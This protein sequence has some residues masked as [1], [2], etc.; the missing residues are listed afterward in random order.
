MTTPFTSSTLNSLYN[1][2]FSEDKNFHQILFNDGRAL[3]ARELTQLQTLI[4]EELGRFGRNIFK[5]GAAVSS[6]GTS[7]NSAYEFVRIA[8]T[9]EGQAFADI[10][11]GTILLNPLTNVE[12]RVL[13]VHPISADF[14]QNTLYVQ[15][16]STGAADVTSVATR[17]GDAETLYDQS[18][19]NYELV[20]DTPN[21]TG[22]GVRFDVFDG[23]FF[24]AGRFVHADA[25]SIVLSP[26]TDTANAVVGFKVVQEIVT[27]NDDISLYD[28]AGG[29]INTASPGGDRYKIT[30]QLTTQDKVTSDDTFVFIARVENSKI[31]EE[32][33]ESDAFNKINDLLALRTNEESG[34][35][36]VNPFS[37][38][39]DNVTD[40]SLDLIISSGT[41]YVNGYR[42]DNPSP[43]R[44]Q[45]PKPKSTE[46]I[47]N[48]VVPVVYGNYFEV[49]SVRG[50]PDLD[51]S[52][53]NLRTA[54]A[55]GGSTIGSAR[56]R[57]VEK[58]Q[59]TYRAY[60]F[61]VLVDSDQ[62]IST[63]Q[64]IG[65][66]ATSYLN[67]LGTLQQTT[68]N[69]LLFPTSRPRPETF[70]DI[71]MVVQDRESKLTD[72]SG[73]LNL[74]QLPVGETYTDTSLWLVA[75]TGETFQAPTIT[76][77]NGNRDA[78]LSG[79]S[80]STTYEIMFYK[81]ITATRKSKTLTTTSTT[82][83]RQTATDVNGNA[84]FYYDLGV[85]DIYQLDSARITDA[86]GADLLGQVSLD[87]G[88]RDNYYADGRII[89]GI[90]DS[91]PA[92][93]YASFQHFT[94]GAGDFYDATSYD[95][96]YADIPTHSKQDGTEVKLFNYLDF[97]PDKNDG[98]FSNINLLPRNGS[99]ITADI[100][101]YLPRADKLLVTQEGDFQVLMGQQSE[102]PQYKKTPE[103][104]LELYKILLN[105]N[106]LDI[107]DM[108]VTP[109]EHK[110]YTMQDIAKIEAKLD[111]L[112]E[113][114][115][116]KFLELEQ[117]P[118]L[119][120]AGVER[121]VS[122]LLADD[123]SDQSASDVTNRDYRASLD[124]E[125]KVIKPMADE[126]NIRLIYDASSTGVTKVGDQ[127][128]LNYDSEQWQFQDL[129]SRFVNINPFGAVDNVGTLKLSPSS[130]E[131]KDS[132]EEAESAIRGSNKLAKS[133][134]MLWNNWSWN[135]GG[136]SSEDIS[137][138][139]EYFTEEDAK[140]KR[141]KV[142]SENEK[143]FSSKSSIGRRAGGTKFVSRVVSDETLRKIANGRVVD[144]AIV[145]WMRSRKIYFHAK[146]L[147]PNSKFT[148]FF[149]G[150]N[151]AVWC[152]QEEAFINWADRDSDQGNLLTQNTLTGRLDGSSELI[153]DDNGE[154]IGS[155][156]IP[157]LRPKYYADNTYK[158]R[159]VKQV[160][161]RFR[162]GTREFK[163]LDIDNNDWAAAGSK[164]FAYYTAEGNIDRTHRNTLFT[165]KPSP[166]SP[167]ANN[168]R[169]PRIYTPVE[170]R[171]VL[172]N[173]RSDQI[174][175]TDPRSSGLYSPETTAIN[176]SGLVT[177]D[178][179][180]QMSSILSDYIDVDKNQYSST[181]T[182]LNNPTNPMTQTFT[183]DNQYGLV[184]T[185][186]DLFFRQKDSGNLPVA[187][188][189]RPVEGGKP[190]STTIVPDSHVWLNPSQVTAI[191]LDPQLS[192]IRANP[193][194]FTFDEPVFLQPWTTY[195]IVVT[196]QSTEYELFSA[197]TKE[198]V[199]GST[200]R[201]VTTQPAPGALYLPQSGRNWVES[202]DQDLMFRL[203]RAK[204]SLGGG[205]LILK[206]APLPEELL[207][208]NPIRTVSGSTEIYIRNRCHGLEVG[209]DV[210][211]QGAVD[212]GSATGTT[213]N[214]GGSSR[215]VTA[216]DL[217]GFKVDIGVDPAVS[218]SGGGEGVTVTKNVVFSTANTVLESTI[219]NKTSIDVGAKL[220]SGKYI[221]G[222]TT[223]F[224]RNETFR[225]VTPNQNVDFD[226]PY[227][228]YNATAETANL[229]AG[230]SSAYIKVDLKTASDYVSPLIDLQRASL[231]LA[232]YC[233][234]N[235]TL[236]PHI[237]P[238]DETSPYGG[239]TGAKHITTPVTLE[240][241]AVGIDTNFKVNLPDGA[242][243]KMYYRTAS[244]DE[245]IYDKRWILQ[246]PQS[247]IP[248]VNDL[249]L[250][251]AQFLAGG[252]GGY[253]KPFNQS[254]IK[255]VGT[256]T[257]QPFLLKD[258]SIRFL[259]I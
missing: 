60:V 222:N 128:T 64:S 187:I 197:K 33:E 129:A 4:Y 113:Y 87:D 221:S 248:N 63:V 31:V 56:I 245:N 246:E 238:V 137:L 254:Q 53:V 145:P 32:I 212:I 38:H 207:D 149:D 110:S 180:G 81:Q 216:I 204:F 51:Y 70:D 147:K 237:Y 82:F 139:P 210:V 199:Y 195:A 72:G 15:Y 234:D 14:E 76:L 205:S 111:K 20:T 46:S 211:I 223:R 17:F 23:D 213:I 73:V 227:A 89:M 44:L 184:L 101:Y 142:I 236:T 178:Q 186:L 154:I 251:N 48:D 108:Q 7:I 257:N 226:T 9:N 231:V 161:T 131:W 42:V 1:D 84:Y 259:A 105:A 175:L 135:W 148:P 193:T 152:R 172:N 230:V 252:R 243:I 117:K 158:K 229:G 25:Q 155:F 90:Q 174:N 3:Q 156:F 47:I 37:I 189:L 69:D 21:A 235:P 45:L 127:A 52:T 19:N 49:D 57:S 171:N 5:E 114:T 258:L 202:K 191:G 123:F 164:A 10:P 217:H 134:A 100:A 150:E 102:T 144:T 188:H 36:V 233:I 203:T 163:L 143:Y 125:S 54:T 11:V 198:T 6:G 61:D 118:S 208:E 95:L 97:R 176:T 253:L 181:P 182:V 166:I 99:S 255:L 43:I 133:Q 55:H 98:T 112:E 224:V 201:T 146:G 126:N 183:V 18:G 190:S 247:A 13:S 140:V 179:Q 106:T 225:R 107:D 27:V 50:L 215:S 162:T 168:R 88:Q 218:T 67:V 66:S 62:D 165:R 22:T 28:N 170:E 78:E 77:S 65:D 192:T 228:I 104:S 116:L 194:T 30:L 138:N 12:A 40:S 74:T 132:K 209:D 160:Y 130:D 119:D 159:K 41:A 2:D 219:P 26:Y 232:G 79:L 173:V 91:A 96:P 93:L 244:S 122:G 185:K 85:P 115:T 196:S 58:Y 75:S 94:R 151:V 256:G 80:Y 157:N 141:R 136:R 83:A 16:T 86:S 120:S 29:L 214:N 177:L 35:Y 92:T 200:T 121:I 34:D 8:S 242:D 59:D 71:T 169:R 250:S 124:P 109:I 167:F 240:E 249:S 39:F 68:D 241:P 220:T 24:V 206:N 153:S 103:N 239:T